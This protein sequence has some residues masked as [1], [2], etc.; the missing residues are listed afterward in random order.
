[1]NYQKLIGFKHKADLNYETY[2]LISTFMELKQYRCLVLM[3]ST[4]VRELIED[5]FDEKAEQFKKFIQRETTGLKQGHEKLNEQIE[6]IKKEQEDIE[7]F[8]HSEFDQLKI[9]RDE[10]QKDI[11][12]VVESAQGVQRWSE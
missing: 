1:M 5:E 8:M 12:K 6:Q 10:M 2:M 4:S 3:S 7:K 11:F 9:K